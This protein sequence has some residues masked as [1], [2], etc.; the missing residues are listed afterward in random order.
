LTLSDISAAID[1]FQLKGKGRIDMI[2]LGP[3]ISDF[4]LKKFSTF[5]YLSDII[6]ITTKQY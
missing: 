3:K 1:T 5:E 2:I 4:E 6:A